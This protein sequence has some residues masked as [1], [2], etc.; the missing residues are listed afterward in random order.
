MMRFF[1]FVVVG[2]LITKII[3]L[4]FRSMSQRKQPPRRKENNFGEQKP[5]PQVEF[6]DIKDADFVDITEKEKVSK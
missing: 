3:G 4:V 2:W 6:K 5:N 1:L